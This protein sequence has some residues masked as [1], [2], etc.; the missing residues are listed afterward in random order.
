MNT[1]KQ[2][3]RYQVFVRF[4]WEDLLLIANELNNP[5]IT[6]LKDWFY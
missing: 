5:E 3:S 2:T 4:S 1:T 6:Y